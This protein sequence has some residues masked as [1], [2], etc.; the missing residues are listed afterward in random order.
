MNSASSESSAVERLSAQRGIVESLGLRFIETHISYVLFDR[1]FAYKIKKA[2]RFPF[3][4]FTTLA[5]REFFCREELRLNRRFAS[6]IYLDVVP[7]V[8]SADA[9]VLDPADVNRSS[10]PI[11]YAVKMR[12]FD[13]DGLLSCVIA[14]DELTTARVDE[15]AA[16]VA[17]FHERTGRVD[18]NTPYGEPRGILTDARENFVAMQGGDIGTAARAELD[19][20]A[21]W[22]ED[23]GRRRTPSFVARRADGLVRECHGD[24]HLG[25]IALVNGLPGTT[26]RVT[27]FD[28]IEFNASMRWIDVMS[29]VAF[30]VMDLRDHNRPDLAARFLNAYLMR[31]GD[32]EGLCVLPFYTVYRALVRAKIACLRLAQTSGDERT[33]LLTGFRAY[34]DLARRETMRTPPSVIIT[35]G[36]SGS[37]KSTRAQALVENGAIAI[38]S[39]VERKRLFGLESGAHSHSPVGGGLYASDV[40]RRTYDRLAAVARTVIG[41]GYTVVVDAA[42]LKRWQRDLLRAVADDLGVRFVIADCSA[43][44]SVLRERVTRRLEHDHDASEATLD[45]LASQLATEEPLGADER[46][47]SV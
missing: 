46:S 17:A 37:G 12:E 23:E 44:Q 34:V 30:L 2:V 8:G 1:G 10:A 45:V 25:N 29:D 6:S 9:P 13:Q 14:R 15:L 41:A 36:V 47:M 7:V 28:C 3:L 22:T 24:L 43:P 32:Y 26:A 27:L 39:D 19:D 35:H 42:F 20:L 31:T 33:A 4:D 18:P 16:E 40:D 5:A 21:G 11:E 38:R